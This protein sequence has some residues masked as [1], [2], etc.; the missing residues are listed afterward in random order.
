MTKPNQFRYK[1]VGRQSK[2][3]PELVTKLEEC[4]AVQ[5]SVAETCFYAG[6]ARQTYY[7]WM[8][9]N[10]E[11]S[12]RMADLRQKPFLRA[13]QTIISRL[14]DVN[15]AF[16]FME[17]IKPDEFA[18]TLKMQ[19]SGEIGDGTPQEDKEVI[20][21]FH[22]RLKANMQKRIKEKSR[23]GESGVGPEPRA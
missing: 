11:L 5:A 6:I 3:T 22:A 15:T 1:Y 20:A 18:D 19:H 10:P 2:L 9:E 7:R 17:K 16:R 14:D 13:R 21:E 12:D 4:A 8:D 23:G